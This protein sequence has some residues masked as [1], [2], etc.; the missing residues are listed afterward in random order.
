MSEQK[1]VAASAAQQAEAAAK[2]AEAAKQ[3]PL[4]EVQKFLQFV[5][6]PVLTGVNNIDSIVN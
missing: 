2:Q 4:A 1:P 3:A 5:F 6:S